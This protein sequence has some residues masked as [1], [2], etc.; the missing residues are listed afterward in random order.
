MPLHPDVVPAQHRDGGEQNAS[1][2]DLLPNAFHRLGDLVC[3]Q[4]DQQGADQSAAD[5]ERE[6]PVAPRDHSCRRRDDR[7]NERGLQ[8]FSENDQC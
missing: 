2:E 5:A 6:P 1:V 4:G 3:E 7:Q 8:N